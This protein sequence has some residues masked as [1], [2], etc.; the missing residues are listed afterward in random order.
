MEEAKTKRKTRNGSID[1][2]RYVCAIMVVA[3][4]TNP[5]SDINEKLGYVFTQIIPRIAVPFFFA[6]AG[7]FYIPRL[8]ED[9]KPFFSY[10][11]RLFIIYFLWSCFYYSIDFV[12][13]G[14]LD[15][16]KFVTGC[17]Y[18]FVIGS[19]YH[20]WFF[21]A[22]LFSVSLTTLMYNTWCRKMIIP[23]SVILY[24]IGCLGCSYYGLGIRIPILRKLF[25]SPGFNLIRRGLLMSYPFF[26]SGYV[27]Y[28]I[29]KKILS[30]ITN[31]KLLAV[32]SVSVLI[33]LS[34]IYIV[35]ML[36][37]Q[38][39]II[40]TAGLYLMV[41]TTLL[42][43]LKKPMHECKIL[44]NMCKVTADF[45][46]YIHPLC[47]NC[48]SFAAKKVLH[49]NVTETILFFLTIGFTSAGGILVYKGKM[50]IQENK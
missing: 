38:K 28:K 26:I 46:Y 3:I 47:I 34:E 50:S 4:H 17:I 48:I 25:V 36:K 39:N 35:R 18:R 21:P 1:M 7:Y 9:Q 14:Y 40:I 42:M 43:L 10:S 2:F 23:F 24:V 32:W 13:G 31:K 29:N 8:E 12:Q 27:G 49:R 5:F 11:K 19:H 6:A 37:W 30:T 20:F 45:I 33:W 15:A 44:S 16:K 22:L 41:V